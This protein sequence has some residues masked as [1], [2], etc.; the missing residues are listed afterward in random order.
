MEERCK[1]QR[2][3]DGLETYSLLMEDSPLERDNWLPLGRT[4]EVFLPSWIWWFGREGRAAL[5]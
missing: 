2:R 5:C 1:V 4:R 3:E